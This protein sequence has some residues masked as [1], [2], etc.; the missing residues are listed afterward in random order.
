MQHLF[1]KHNIIYL[2][3]SYDH[4]QDTII[5]GGQTTIKT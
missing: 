4:I 2:T 3:I 5:I 1:S